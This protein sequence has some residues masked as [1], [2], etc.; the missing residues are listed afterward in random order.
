MSSLKYFMK[1]ELKKDE[2]VEVPGTETFADDN[3]KPVPFLIKKI[4]VEEMNRIRQNY[5]VK[6]QAR[7]EKG[8]PI[9]DK[10]GNL[11]F[12]TEV[13]DSKVT[14]RL[15]VESLVQPNLKDP[16]L[17]KFYECVDVMEMPYKIF[18]KPS[19]YKYISNQVLLVNDLIEDKSDEELVEEVKN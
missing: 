16:E 4:G 3:G 2:I 1:E 8:K 10:F 18:K 11:V 5:T 14:N 13:D 19:D 17:M 9:L 6:K 15:I 7:N 12:I